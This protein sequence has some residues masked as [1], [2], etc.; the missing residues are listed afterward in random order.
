VKTVD[1][2][3]PEVVVNFAAESHLGVVV[4]LPTADGRLLQVKRPFDTGSQLSFLREGLLRRYLPE[5]LLR[6][7]RCPYRVKGAGGEVLPVLGQIDINC[8]V[9]GRPVQQTF[10]VAQIAENVLLG[11]DFIAR[12]RANWN[13]RV[14]R[15][16]FEEPQETIRLVGVENVPS[17]AMKSMRVQVDDL[18][19][20][21]M[22]Y[23]P[24]QT[25]T[26]GVEVIASCDLV[27]NGHIHAGVQNSGGL[28][29]EVDLADIRAET[30]EPRD[31][32]EYQPEW[33]TTKEVVCGMVGADPEPDKPT[34][35][36]SP[37]VLPLELEKM[38][39]RIE[40]PLDT[41][42]ERK[43]RGVL[44]DYQDVFVLEG[45]T[46]GRTGL[47]KHAIRLKDPTPIKQPPRR[48]PLHREHI[49]DEEM[50]KM[51]ASDAIRPSTSPWASPIVLVKKK[52]D[53]TRF[54]VDYRKV[55]D[56]TIKDA[57]PLPRIEESLDALQGAKFFTT[58]DLKSGYWQVE[59]KE[60]DKPITAFST[61]H[62]LYEWN[63][64]PFGLTNAPATFQ[65]LMEQV[66]QGL[67]WK[68]LA[69]HLD[70]II[71]YA[72]TADEH[73]RRLA[74]VLERCRTAGLK[75]KTSK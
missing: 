74:L 60:E 35:P 51:K 25:L 38:I 26:D 3:S 9:E 11:L 22:V 52:D 5:L 34:E 41:V 43:L 28:P 58:L 36:K 18:K 4:G 16:D 63:V 48:V 59:M 13:W 72:P 45:G 44:R 53:T 73:V 68:I 71:I 1:S 54:C 55:N 70:D 12:Y 32:V 17:E 14:H 57:Y 7:Q 69:L 47:V 8:R 10:V 2:G 46:L 64:M 24:A 21:Q 62:G 61:K 66:L 30:I 65:R 67:Q 29:A 50:A 37:D 31:W 42:A 15:M 40:P 33:S 49:V 20:G 6:V 23:V 56:V 39:Y 75:L 19:S 27:E